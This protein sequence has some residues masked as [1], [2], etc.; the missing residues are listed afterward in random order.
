MR[1]LAHPLRLQ[2]LGFIDKNDGINVNQIYQA[3]KIEQSVTSQHL[4][5]MKMAGIVSAEKDGKFVTYNID[6]NIIERA[7]A[8]VKKF[9]KK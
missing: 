9:L 6:Y 1:A 5:I 3:L 7:N 4:K 2:I 8:A